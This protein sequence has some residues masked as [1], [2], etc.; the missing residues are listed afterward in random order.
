VDAVR[1]LNPAASLRA[2]Q[3]GPDRR[4][5]SV[6]TERL[7]LVSTG[8]NSMRF[9]VHRLVALASF[10]VM[11]AAEAATP[12]PSAL[13]PWREWVSHGEE[14]RAC[15]LIAGTDGNAAQDF[16]CAWPGVLAIDAGADGATFR[17]HWHVDAESSIPLPG[18]DAHWPV[19]VTVDGKAAPIVNAGGPALRLDAGS[20]EVRGRIPWN[21]RPETL[22]VPESA[23]LVALAV[24]GTS[25]TPAERDGGELTLGRSASLAPEAD[26]MELRVHRRL[27]DGVPAM[28]TTRIEIGA[29]GQAR[30]EIIGPALPDGFVPLSLSGEW[31]ARLDADGRLRV[32]V[33]PGTATLT[34][35]ARATS[36]L[37]SVALHVPAAPWPAQEIWSYAAD[38]RLRTTTAK[39][40]VQVDPRQADVPSA[41]L[42]LP[43]FALADGAT[44]AIDEETRGLAPDDR[45]R[46]T[47]DREMWLD[48]DG[49]GWFARDR[50]RGEML[51]GWRF[52]AA[53]PFAI[54]R[55][56]A[57]G[58]GSGGGN[59]AL[60]VTHGTG[61][62][63]T[64][65]EWRTPAVD[66]SAGL[67]ITNARAPMPASGWQDTFDRVTTTLHL[68]DG[69]RLIA[70]PGADSAAGSWISRW[71]LLDVFI[72][73]IVVLL[74]W[75][76]LGIAGAIVASLY[77]VLGY[78]ESGAPMWTLLAAIALGLVVVALP[79]GRLATAAQWIRR[80]AL[81]LLVLVALP[82]VAEQLRYA[83][84][85]QLESDGQILGFAGSEAQNVAPM[86]VEEAASADAAPPPAPA[87]GSESTAGVVRKRAS[88][89]AAKAARD[90]SLQTVTV[91]G[92]T[93]RRA[94]L[95]G[96]YSES[97]VVQTGAGEPAWQRA[98][99]Y[100]LGWSGPVLPTQHV[101]LVI[102]PPWLVRVLRVVLVALLAWLVARS[103]LPLV[104]TR[105]WS[106]TA[107]LG[108]FVIGSL[109][110]AEPTPANAQTFPTQELLDELRSRLSAPPDCAPACATIESAEVSARDDEIRVVLIAHAAG[111]VALPMPFDEKSLAL[112][113]VVVDGSMQDG[114][115]RAN[116]KSW[117]AL[118]RGVHRVE[119]AFAT[120]SDKIA[121][122][123][124]LKPMRVAF[125]GQGWD[126][127]GLG[128]G[129]LLTETLTLARAHAEGAETSPSGAQQF[130]P[131]V[132]V[133][134][135]LDLGLD[136]ST[137]VR[138]QR[139]APA[140]GGFT[141]EVPLIVG[142][143]VLTAGTKVGNDR[144]TVAIADG[145]LLAS[146]SSRL[147]KA[148]TLSMT[149]P[150]LSDRAEIW[151]VVV[152]PTWHVEFAGVPPIAMASDENLRDYRNFEFHPLPGET[153]NIRVTRPAAAQGATRAIDS[154]RF[155][156]AIGQRATTST[157]GLTVRASRGG[158]EIVEL[159]AS[160][161][162]VG[163]TR[164]GTALNLRAQDGKLTLPIV[165][166]T[167]SFEIRLR[168]EKPLGFVAQTPAI[169]LA[170]P[171]AN[172]DLALDLPVDRWL[173]G[174]FGPP[175]G[176]AVLYWSALA[177]V[178]VVAWAIAR[179]RRT[180]LK[181]WQLILLGI[182]FSTFSWI[183]PLVVVAWLA[184]IDWRMRAEPPSSVVAFDL[185][186]IGLAALTVLA[187]VCLVAAI[188]QGLLGSPDM[189]IAGNGSYGHSLR[190]F[191]DRSDGA[192]PTAGTVS[193]PLWVYK[194][195]MLA[196]ALWLAS[197]V[198]GWLR[199]GFA[200][201]TRDGYWRKRPQKAAI[202]VPA[203][204][205]PPLSGA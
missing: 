178:L 165:P 1:E 69:Y 85:P 110:F 73:A 70:A 180:P 118:S 162:V 7:G 91:T 131:F 36:P 88:S 154:V 27:A 195:L 200:A 174:T 58:T 145:E 78:Q 192:L 115:A 47:L 151:R 67:R 79:P 119:L 103:I 150:P 168:E 204:S 65:V 49:N 107:A 89:A 167:H 33:E 164:D 90:E 94:D 179:T 116:G 63:S 199:Y 173:L 127:S 189:Q 202:D 117:L 34:L 137:E 28:L 53:A 16:L 130:A 25:V 52:D 71:T 149:A 109:V 201:W 112:R 11:I 123:F 98:R 161:E 92:S 172:I 121:L 83:L 80:A 40:T 97:T 39:S 14:F 17:Q 10:L 9:F 26:S 96:H 37:A 100:V 60:L 169:R 184:A 43:A 191:A 22:R 15:P 134:R 68:P 29:S 175:S 23:G 158:D 205:A 12:V 190:W 113:T 176:P 57:L 136:W 128:D 114:L 95:I 126:A 187:L 193:A 146:W 75:R 50:V 2:L 32:R 66:L 160:L 133:E 31:P 148:E 56:E 152:S 44:L 81:L 30:E 99:R 104:R 156:E 87:P 124:P 122:A 157:L 171:A 19:G 102:A 108:A 142:E 138:V 111:R 55:A 170:S 24:D 46:L 186:Q 38:P 35:E 153:L 197:A 143:H 64:G 125:A 177:V 61:E 82:F 4:G 181:L 21:E 72:A 84:H 188:P 41:W 159:A 8:G 77:L 166:G 155:A 140:S 45:N 132:R 141:A 105:R 129:R 62:G 196:W 163:A 101:R 6:I 3:S 144:A 59:E 74:A 48:F 147:D 18:D 182:G 198:V 194:V 139:L 51:R 86:Q 54:E 120:T 185:V 20:Y 183:A 13:E 135:S 106:A 76:A 42:D 93:I 5:D 203:A